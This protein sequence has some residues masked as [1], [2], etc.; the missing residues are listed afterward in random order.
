[1]PT[2]Q[3]SVLPSCTPRLLHDEVADMF[4]THTVHYHMYTGCDSACAT[5]TNACSV[6]PVGV[7][8]KRVPANAYAFRT[9]ICK[10]EKT[11]I[12]IQV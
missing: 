7:G 11:N 10:R 12:P 4:H 6:R 3:P 5:Y 1:M 9:K 2:C 8:D